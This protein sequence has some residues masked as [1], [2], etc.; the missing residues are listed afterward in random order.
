MAL[1]DCND[2]IQQGHYV[3]AFL[4]CGAEIPLPRKKPSHHLALQD[5]LPIDSKLLDAAFR[6][7]DEQ[8]REKH[9]VLVY[10]GHG[11]SRSAS[12][13]AGYVALKSGE[14]LNDVLTPNPTIAPS[15]C[16]V[17][18]NVSIDCRLRE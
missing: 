7:L 12:V 1:G 18:R 2:P 5:G 9:F 15:G 17:C 11:T 13:I 6:F 3:D 4:C 10:C 8:L 16:A 14:E